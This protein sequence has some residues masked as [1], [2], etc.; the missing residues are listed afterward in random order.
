MRELSGKEKIRGRFEAFIFLGEVLRAL[1]R[2]ETVRI[3][4]VCHEVEAGTIIPYFK[5]KFGLKNIDS[6]VD[7]LS[8]IAS[9][10][11]QMDVS[12]NR[13]GAEGLHQNGLTYLVHLIYE[14]KTQFL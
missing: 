7:G 4:E 2:E 5:Q 1:D 8:L 12:E 6:S 13:A 3:S 11:A 14:A 10:L 9:L